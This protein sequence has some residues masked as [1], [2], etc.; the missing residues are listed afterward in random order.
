MH[1]NVC[2]LYKGLSK[3]A[4]TKTKWKSISSQISIFGIEIEDQ[5]MAFFK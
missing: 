3:E 4:S 2:I 1:L 5:L